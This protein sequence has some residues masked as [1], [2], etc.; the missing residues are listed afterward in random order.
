M[1]CSLAKQGVG[2]SWRA[3]SEG[4]IL[5]SLETK[6]LLCVVIS[7]W[8]GVGWGERK[9]FMGMRMRFYRGCGAERKGLTD[10]QTCG[11]IEKKTG[12]EDDSSL[13]PGLLLHSQS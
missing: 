10:R 11:M 12:P 3:R 4:E 1:E 13:R 7:G 2:P 6:G 9:W 8:G 5:L